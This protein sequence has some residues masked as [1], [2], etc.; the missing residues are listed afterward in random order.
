MTATTRKHNPEKQDPKETEKFKNKETSELSARKPHE[1]HTQKNTTTKQGANNLTQEKRASLKLKKH[2]NCLPENHT[3]KN[4]T[5]NQEA[6]SMTKRSKGC[7]RD[8]L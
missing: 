2:K 6:N 4:T 3:Q 1:N 8:A 7:Q 5:T